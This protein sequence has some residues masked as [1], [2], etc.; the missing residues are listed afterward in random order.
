VSIRPD[1]AREWGYPQEFALLLDDRCLVSA[2]A[3]D[4]CTMATL[5]V[6]VRAG[7]RY[8]LDDVEVAIVTAL[9][10]YAAPR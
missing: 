6:S 10:A 3:C 7:S 8:A 2:Q 4:A 1:D 5:P 9:A